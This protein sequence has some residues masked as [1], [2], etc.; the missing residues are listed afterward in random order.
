MKKHLINL[1]EN[2]DL[3]ADYGLLDKNIQLSKEVMVH[4]NAMVEAAKKDGVTDFLISSGYRG[5]KQQK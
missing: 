4:F 5:F 1:F 3:I 2:Q